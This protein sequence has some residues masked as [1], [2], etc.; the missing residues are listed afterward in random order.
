MTKTGKRKAIVVSYEAQSE[1][2]VEDEA[3]DESIS[4]VGVVV[5][6]VRVVADTRI[7]AD[8]GVW[9]QAG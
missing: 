3:I 9:W 8:T 4:D 7:V 6:T 1:E 5:V 2:D